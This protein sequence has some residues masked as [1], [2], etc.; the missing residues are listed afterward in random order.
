MSMHVLTYFR[1]E[2]ISLHFSRVNFVFYLLPGASLK[3]LASQYLA[4]SS[5][6]EEVSQ[7][8]F[9]TPIQVNPD[10]RETK[11]SFV[12]KPMMLLRPLCSFKR[13]KAFSTFF[14]LCRKVHRPM[15]IR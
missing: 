2:L 1:V 6:S 9:S 8:D 7:F 4:D 3:Y 12:L 5:L 14:R 15:M 10:R 11:V 13:H